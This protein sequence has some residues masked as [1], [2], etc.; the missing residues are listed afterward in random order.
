[1]KKIVLSLVILAASTLSFA[2]R[3]NVK[4]DPLDNTPISI[5]PDIE[6]KKMDITLVCYWKQWFF[7]NLGDESN[8][9]KTETISVQIETQSSI[10][11]IS[12]LAIKEFRIAKNQYCQVKFDI[13]VES[14]KYVLYDDSFVSVVT[15]ET[16]GN[17]T[18]QFEEKL[19]ERTFTPVTI[20]NMKDETV[21]NR[22]I[23]K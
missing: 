6:I 13:K 1:M 21:L 22:V 17:L 16:N 20:V 7:Q 5:A 15:F 4:L 8:V 11:T 10:S 18:E 12:E 19:S 9:S 3:V 14:D 23:L 2:G